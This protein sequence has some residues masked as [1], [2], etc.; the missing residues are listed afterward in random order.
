MKN[1]HFQLPSIVM[2]KA[3]TV[4]DFA[5]TLSAVIAPV[6]KQLPDAIDKPVLIRPDFDT[7]VLWKPPRL[8]RSR[9]TSTESND[10]LSGRR[11]SFS[12][13]SPPVDTP[14]SRRFSFAGIFFGSA[15]RF[16]SAQ[17]SPPIAEV[18]DAHIENERKS[19]VGDRS[20]HVR[21]FPRAVV[22]F[23]VERFKCASFATLCNFG[24]HMGLFFDFPFE[25]PNL[26]LL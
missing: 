9:T 3:P 12:D 17:Y 2:S 4:S 19:S 5:S 11:L 16:T 21:L 13:S 22:L 18:S 23:V 24:Y 7:D 8:S 10:S 14:R 1:R 15:N 26:L 6:S 25:D 20:V